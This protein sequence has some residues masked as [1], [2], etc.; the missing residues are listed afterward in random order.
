MT[1]LASRNDLIGSAYVW[2]W[3]GEYALA[4]NTWTQSI[5]SNLVLRDIEAYIVSSSS[6][7]ILFGSDEWW[8]PY[9]VSVLICIVHDE[10][11]FDRF[12]NARYA[13]NH[14]IIIAFTHN[15]F[16]DNFIAL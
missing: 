13:Y 2:Q 10:K 16:L 4:F 5:F 6:D 12:Y 8:G 7:E 9:T 15:Y 14:L 1:Q 11:W 3:I